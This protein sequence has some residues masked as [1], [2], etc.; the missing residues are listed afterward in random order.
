MADF[1]RVNCPRCGRFVTKVKSVQASFEMNC[2]HCHCTIL[3]EKE[4]DDLHTRAVE[5]DQVKPQV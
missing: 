5:R 2:G 3:V 1:V 4:G